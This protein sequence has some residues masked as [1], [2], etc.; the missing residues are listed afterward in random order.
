VAVAD[1]FLLLPMIE[2]AKVTGTAAG[3]VVTC[4]KRIFEAAAIAA[5]SLMYG[6]SRLTA[7]RTFERG[8]TTP[9]L[10]NSWPFIA[11]TARSVAS[12]IPALEELSAET[13][14][15]AAASEAFCN[16]V[17]AR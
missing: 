14:A 7:K 10:L 8:K 5:A 11:A 13:A 16:S 9:V 6:P 1:R 3:G 4:T 12:V 2:P 17:F 15:S